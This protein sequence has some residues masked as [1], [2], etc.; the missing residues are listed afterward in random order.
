MAKE[1][2]CMICGYMYKF[3]HH[4]REYQ[5]QP[6][7]KYLYHDEKCKAIGDIWYAYR[8][9]EI[10]KGDARNR[11]NKLKPNIDAALRYTGTIASNEIREI[12]DITDEVKEEIVV[13][14][15]PEVV[16]EAVSE[17]VETAAEVVERQHT[18]KKRNSKKTQEAE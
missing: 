15:T 11:L 14:T 17:V 1:R 4:C 3:C 5:N 6:S 12:F 13:E 7:W 18:S 10:S 9:H 16:N 2:T 8:G